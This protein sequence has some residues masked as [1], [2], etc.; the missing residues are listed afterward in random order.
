LKDNLT[1]YTVVKQE[2]EV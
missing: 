2:S 1:R